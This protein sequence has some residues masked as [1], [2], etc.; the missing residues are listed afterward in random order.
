MRLALLDIDTL[1]LSNWI[2]IIYNDAV[3]VIQKSGYKSISFEFLL[4]NRPE[5]K[6]TQPT[7]LY[8]QATLF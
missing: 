1:S 6:P 8:L 4:F 5:K 2:E 3:G 7:N